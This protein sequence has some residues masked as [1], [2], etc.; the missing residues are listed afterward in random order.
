MAK[1]TGIRRIINAFGYSWAGLRS[2]FASEA[3]FRQEMALCAVL[4]PL[5]FLLEVTGIERH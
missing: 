4:V 1:A 3:A 2:V 5:A